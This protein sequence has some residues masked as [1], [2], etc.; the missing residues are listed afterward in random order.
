[1][2]AEAT[3]SASLLFD[4]GIVNVPGPQ[5]AGL[6]FDISGAK[7]NK[8]VQNVGTSEEALQLGETSGS[9]GWCLIKNLDNTNYVKLKTA[10]SGTIF[11]K[12]L[13]KGGCA[14]F[15]FGS[16]VTAPFVQADTAACNIEIY[17]LNQ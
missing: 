8:T 12:L 4:N 14:L 10:T 7:Y 17:I 13:P 1:M 11:A 9:L 5:V 6:R 16:D 2:A 15:Y 3:I